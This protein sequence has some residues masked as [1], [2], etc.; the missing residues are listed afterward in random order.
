M[1]F[2]VEPMDAAIERWRQMPSEEQLDIDLAQDAGS[3][4]LSMR[5]PLDLS[6]LRSEEGRGGFCP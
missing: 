5:R 4:R 6:A 1:P 2:T 3:K